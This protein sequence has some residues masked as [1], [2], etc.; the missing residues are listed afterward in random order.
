MQSL[1]GGLWGRKMG[2]DDPLI[3]A[4]ALGV[5]RVVSFTQSLLI[6]ALT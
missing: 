6:K 5:N 1:V 2:H 4:I 3:D